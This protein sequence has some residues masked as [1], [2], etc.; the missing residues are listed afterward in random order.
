MEV[1]DVSNLLFLTGM[2]LGL[3]MI[4]H[5]SVFTGDDVDHAISTYSFLFWNAMLVW[6]YVGAL[7]LYAVICIIL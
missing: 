5:Y 4:S 7:C 1:V 3:F 2:S 6:W